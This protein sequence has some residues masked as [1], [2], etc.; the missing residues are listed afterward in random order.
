MTEDCR[1][2]TSALRY[3]VYCDHQLRSL[4]TDISKVLVCQIMMAPAFSQTVDGLEMF[5]VILPVFGYCE[6]SH[7]IIILCGSTAY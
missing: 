7:V 6:A 5:N 1:L 4:K 3:I 2:Y